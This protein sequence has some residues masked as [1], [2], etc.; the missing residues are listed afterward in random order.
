MLETRIIK[1]EISTVYSRVC[2]NIVSFP[3]RYISHE[4]YKYAPIC[5]PRDMQYSRYGF[6]LI[7][8]RF[9]LSPLRQHEWKETLIGLEYLWTPDTW[10]LIFFTFLS[11]C[12]TSL[13]RVFCLLHFCSLFLI[14]AHKYC[15]SCIF[16]PTHFSS[17]YMLHIFPY[18]FP[19]ILFS[20]RHT[21]VLRIAHVFRNIFPFSLCLPCLFFVSCFWLGSFLCGY[22]W[23]LFLSRIAVVFSTTRRPTVHFHYRILDSLS[24]AV[25]HVIRRDIWSMTNCVNLEIKEIV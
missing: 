7:A 16:S 10:S 18:V 3:T 21:C 23:Y 17:C 24:S 2:G 8:H 6:L 5:I 9:L 13:F 22:F 1:S 4:K 20:L 25:A 19:L 11:I 14:H 12:F 15:I